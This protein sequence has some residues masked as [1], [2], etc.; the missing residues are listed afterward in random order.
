MECALSLSTRLKVRSVTCV[1]GLRDRTIVLLQDTVDSHMVFREMPELLAQATGASVVQYDR[2]GQGDSTGFVLGHKPGN[3]FPFRE[4]E[5]LSLLLQ[6]LRVDLS[7]ML[8]V[9]FGD[10]ASIVLAHAATA[11]QVPKGIVLMNPRWVKYYALKNCE[12]FTHRSRL[13]IEQRLVDRMSVLKND[14]A[15]VLQEM[16]RQHGEKAD[17]LFDSFVD[18]WMDASQMSME[19]FDLRPLAKELRCP[20]LV[21]HT[22]NDPFTTFEAQIEPLMLVAP[23]AAVRIQALDRTVEGRIP[24]LE[25][26]RKNSPKTV[27]SPQAVSL[28]ADFYNSLF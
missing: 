15:K 11:S 12:W 1:G 26:P 6:L 5:R 20:A 13:V 19:D 3:D 8:L 25:R 4:S 28:I 22:P 14:R 9:G 17:A 10:G 2:S 24:F 16:R 27:V 18:L 23:S 7:N 21:L